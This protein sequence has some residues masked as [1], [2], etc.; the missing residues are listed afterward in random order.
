MKRMAWL[1]TGVLV[2]SVGWACSAHS[3][4]AGEIG[5]VEQFALAR[6]REASLKQLIPGTED[7]YYYHCLHFQNLEQFDRVEQFLQEWIKRFQYTPRV[8]EIQHRQA[9]LTYR[10]DPQKSLDYLQRTLNLQ[11]NHQ[12]ETVGASP[13][14]PT[15]LDQTLFARSV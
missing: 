12:R 15:R 3:T 13:D 8:R 4:G 11:F 10:L 1:V 5:Y 7:F 14:L 6:D 2:G 9:L